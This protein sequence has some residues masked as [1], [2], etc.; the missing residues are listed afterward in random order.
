VSGDRSPIRRVE[1]LAERLNVALPE[2]AEDPELVPP[3]DLFERADRSLQLR[4]ELSR[5]CLA[6]AVP[7]RLL[8]DDAALVRSELE[9]AAD[10]P[11]GS[12]AI[13]RHR[14]PVGLRYNVIVHFVDA[15]AARH[16]M[17]GSA[18]LDEPRLALPRTTRR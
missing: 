9:A 14:T 1:V 6:P 5:F 4:G 3:V 17:Q 16:A 10:G 11:E 12:V 18:P 15:H 13:Y 8:P 2:S 7:V